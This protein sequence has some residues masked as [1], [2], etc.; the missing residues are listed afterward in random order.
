M[1]FPYLSS[2]G[3]AS[4]AWTW[5]LGSAPWQHVAHL[6]CLM[7]Y[8]K[9]KLGSACATSLAECDLGWSQGLS[10]S[11]FLLLSMVNSNTADSLGL[12]D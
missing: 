12:E 8:L 9:R 2:P 11:Q 3:F 4:A 6:G 1:P 10:L 5:I 7:A